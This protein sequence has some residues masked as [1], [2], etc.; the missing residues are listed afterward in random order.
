MLINASTD[1]QG[2]LLEK[3]REQSRRFNDKL[4]QLEGAYGSK[5][6]SLREKASESRMALE[7]ERKQFQASLQ[8]LEK[9][10]DDRLNAINAEVKHDLARK[11]EELDLLRDAVQTEKVKLAKLK[12]LLSRY[13]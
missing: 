12:K 13:Q 9:A 2:R 4:S 1:V 3:H 7:R 11:D 5:L 10:H 8:S 6:K